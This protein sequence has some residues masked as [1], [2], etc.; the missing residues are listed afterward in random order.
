MTEPNRTAYDE[1]TAT[2]RDYYNSDDADT[3]YA[4]VWGGEDIHVGLYESPGEP[5]R[6]ASRRTVDHLAQRVEDL[7]GPDAH[8]LDIG[9]GYGGAARRLVDKYGCRIACLNLSEAEN[10]RNRAMNEAAGIAPRIEVIDGAFERVPLGDACVDVVWCQD[11]ILHSGDRRRVLEEVDRV[12]RPGGRFVFTDPMRADDCPPGVLGPILERIHLPDLGSPAFYTETA[13]KL[14]WRDLGF[15]EMTGQL[16]NHYTR[17]LETTE[18]E[19]DRLRGKVSDAYI[20]R[21][22]NGLRHW[23]EG[24]KAGHL[25]WGVFLFEKPE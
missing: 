19:A 3:F 17:V 20:D 9:A 18:A 8:V 15:E 22:K 2:A 23:I 24:G 13:N 12:L 14:G 6:D 21:M 11:A 1:A 4:E 16:V 5:I 10:E 25:A 7:L